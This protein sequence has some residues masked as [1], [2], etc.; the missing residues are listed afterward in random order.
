MET[1]YTVERNAQILIYLLKKSNI[2]KI[3][4]SPGTSNVCFAGSIIN[5]PFFEKYSAVDERSAAYMACGL[6]A[7]S[8]EPVVLSCT[9]ATSSRN[10]LPALTEAYYRK[11]PILTV[12]SSQRSIRIGHNIDQV[13][14]RTLLPR[15]AAKL[16]VQMPCVFDNEMEWACMIAA[17]KAILELSR[18]GSGPVHINLET[19]INGNFSVKELPEARQILRYN[20]NSIFPP[21]VKGKIAILVGNHKVW[22]EQLTKLV[23]SFCKQY[24]AIVICD[25]TSNYMGNYKI[26]GNFLLS[27][28][29]YDSL[30][31]EFDLII[32]LGDIS[33][34]KYKI[35]TKQIWRVN[36]DGEIRDTYKKLTKVFACDE[37]IF[38]RNYISEQTHD[39][40]EG[41]FQSCKKEYENLIERIPELPL[42]NIWLSKVT[43]PLLPPQSVLHFA[44]R[45]SFRSWNFYDI[46]K[47]V[48]AYCNTGGF[49]IDGCMSSMIGASLCNADII[50]YCIIG[51]LAFFYDMNVLG[52]R[53]VS[54]NVRILLVNNGKAMEMS[55]SSNMTS[56]FEDGITNHSFMAAQGHFG[57]QS[58]YLVKNYVTDLGFDYYPVKTKDDYLAVLPKFTDNHISEKPI[59]VEVFTNS[60]DEQLALDLMTKSNMSSTSELK[61]EL[62]SQARKLGINKITRIF[63]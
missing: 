18:D 26:I 28:K 38:F 36:P 6:S 41:F 20:N 56:Q 27:Q 52:N 29:G 2:R 49:G 58:Q 13:T 21:I 61:D 22:S 12:T 17:N 15:D 43:S 59:F 14:D 24:N 47:G 9:G 4:I 3:I 5:D 34:C 10:Y 57:A 19:S 40:S 1:M 33:A 16:S 31:N 54:N 62:L 44:I 32:H 48:R 8:G 7:E 35:K 60:S 39:K 11:L 30:L 25:H 46:P 55:F 51:D 63:K 23:D 45:N 37:D 53:H 50:Y 42:S